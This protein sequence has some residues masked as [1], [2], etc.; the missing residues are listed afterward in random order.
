MFSATTLPDTYVARIAAM[1]AISFALAN[2]KEHYNRIHQLLFMKIGDWAML[3]LHKV[4]SIPSSIEVTK[5][6]TQ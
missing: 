1:D 6:L 5:K 4:Y 2:H 3:K